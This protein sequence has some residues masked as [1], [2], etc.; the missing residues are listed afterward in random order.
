MPN[1]SCSRLSN[2]SNHFA[3]AGHI[4]AFQRPPEM[5]TQYTRLEVSMANNIT[6][7]VRLIHTTK[8][9][10]HKVKALKR[11]GNLNTAIHP[12]THHAT[13]Y[14]RILIDTNGNIDGNI[15]DHT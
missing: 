5:D 15:G 13:Y 3:Q 4:N 6:L 14:K 8:H 12:P 7:T 1:K 10:Q 2:V 9:T 11:L